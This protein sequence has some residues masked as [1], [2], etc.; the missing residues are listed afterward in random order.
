MSPIDT[1]VLNSLLDM[2]GGEVEILADIIHTYLLESPP[3]LTVIQTSVKN[4]DAD[5]LNKAAHQ[6]KSSSA[7][8]GAVN[9][10]RLCL[11]LE[12]KGKN[13]NLEGVLELVSRLKDEYKQVEIA[14]KQIA[15]IP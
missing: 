15:K 4:E 1:Q 8:L 13:Q 10:S 3:I 11:E 12:L 2:I 9:F 14:L 6:L 7:S 5:A